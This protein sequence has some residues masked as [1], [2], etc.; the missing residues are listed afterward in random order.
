MDR[1]L[2]DYSPKALDEPWCMGVRHIQPSP[3]PS[4]T[5]SRESQRRILNAS[6]LKA[7]APPQTGSV[8]HF[9][10][11]TPGPNL[12]ITRN[13]V[14]TW[15]VFFRDRNGRQKRDLESLPGRDLGRRA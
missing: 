6:T 13:D 9:D 15:T 2:F 1:S 5:V 4:P 12:R 3:F 7:L 8:D 14:R 10:N 11:R